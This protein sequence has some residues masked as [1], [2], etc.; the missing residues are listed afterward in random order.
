MVPK[1]PLCY[2]TEEFKN[3]MPEYNLSG[4]PHPKSFSE[5]KMFYHTYKTHIEGRRTSEPSKVEDVIVGG[6]MAGLGL[7]SIP[8]WL[9]ALAAKGAAIISAKGAG[10]TATALV[11]GVNLLAEGKTPKEVAKTMAKG[12]AVSVLIE[13]PLEDWF[14]EVQGH[15]K[16]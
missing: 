16:E 7:V 1:A 2:N 11:T 15:I 9:P 10:L 14:K 4:A 12:L 5:T 13:G 8:L 6:I 3:S